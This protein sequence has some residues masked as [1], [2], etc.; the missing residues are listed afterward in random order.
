[1]A[2]FTTEEASFIDWFK[3]SGGTVHPSVGLQ[4][5]EGAGRGGV[6]SADIEVR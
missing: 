4:Q 1:M 2:S 5:F 6:A 3:Q